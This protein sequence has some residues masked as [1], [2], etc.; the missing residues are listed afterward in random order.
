M[1]G[2]D[3][4]HDWLTATQFQLK[5]KKDLNEVAVLVFS[6]ERTDDCIKQV[7]FCIVKDKPSDYAIPSFQPEGIGFGGLESFKFPMDKEFTYTIIAFSKDE[8]LKGDFGVA[9]FVPEGSAVITDLISF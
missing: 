8:S 2:K 5:T 1:L 7:G 3:L 4:S 9:V 6:I